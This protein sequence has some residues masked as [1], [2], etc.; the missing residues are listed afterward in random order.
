MVVALVAACA[1]Y[2]PAARAAR[3]DPL[4]VIRNE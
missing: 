3:S 1:R 4:R 2:L